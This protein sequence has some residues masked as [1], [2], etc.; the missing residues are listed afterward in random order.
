MGH[1]EAAR[2]LNDDLAEV[3]AMG[4]TIVDEGDVASLCGATCTSSL[5]DLDLEAIWHS[6]S[7]LSTSTPTMTA[8]PWLYWTT[9]R[10]RLV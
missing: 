3:G 9:A 1:T 10:L 8:W 6:V 2:T 4:V 5:R 7:G